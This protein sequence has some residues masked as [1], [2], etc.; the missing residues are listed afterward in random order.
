MRGCNMLFISHR[1]NTVGPKPELENTEG[2]IQEAL[3]KQYFVEVDVWKIKDEWLLGHDEPQHATSEKFISQ[4]RLLLHAKNLEAFKCMIDL[5]LHC[6][7]HQEDFYA[8]TSR[9]II[10]S[11]PGYASGKDTI[12]MQP[13]LLSM[14]TIA[15]A[16]AICSDYIDVFRGVKEERT[17]NFNETR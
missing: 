16:Y 9:G 12:C 13:E 10:I 4:P 2:H 14:D 7:W 1:G 3:N 6:F 8:L 11:Y 17:V 5:E 15:D